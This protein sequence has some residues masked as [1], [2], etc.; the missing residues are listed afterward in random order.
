[1]TSHTPARDR[2]EPGRRLTFRGNL[3]L[4]KPRDCYAERWVRTV[5]AE[6]TD[7]MLI[8]GDAHLRAVAANL[9]RTLQR[10]PAPPVP[11]AAAT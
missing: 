5:R 1:M 8:Y 7:R 10:A 3:T 2:P 4:P 9:R 11:A 6:C